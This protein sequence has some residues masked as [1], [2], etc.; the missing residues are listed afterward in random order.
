MPTQSLLLLQTLLDHALAE[1]DS[2][3]AA[4]RQAEAQTEQAQAQGRALS[5]YRNEQDQRWLLRLRQASGPELLHHHRNFGQRLDQ[6]IHLQAGQAEQLGQ[7]LRQARA[8]LQMREQR[9]AAVRKL[10]DRRQAELQQITQRREQRHTDEAAQRAH[11]QRLG[12]H[13]LSS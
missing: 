2:A 12:L 13:P 6:A 8:L 10:I 9:V 5:D 11:G 7:R 3:A 1:R 4:L